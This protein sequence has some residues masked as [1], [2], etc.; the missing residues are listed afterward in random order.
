MLGNVS[1]NGGTVSPGNSPGTLTIGSSGTPA[2]VSFNS[3]P[4]SI[5]LWELGT[6]G[7]TVDPSVS[8]GGSSA[9]GALHDVLAVNG[10]LDLTNS[11]LNLV[12]LPSSNFV[13][14]QPY[15]WAI[16]SASSS[17]TGIPSIGLISGSDFT[18]GV[19][20]TNF[21][22]TNPGGGVLFLNYSPV[23]EPAFV[24]FACG[25]GVGAIGW[26]NRRRRLAAV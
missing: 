8:P 18:T 20:P 5:Y 15:S 11:T 24:L 14:S 12:S 10:T 23:P 25:T 7:P 22:V 6:A 9:G 26:W 17:L 3:T 21:M 19:S 2:T 1:V 13:S 4:T 16:A